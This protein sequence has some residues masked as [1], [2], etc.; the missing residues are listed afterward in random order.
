MSPLPFVDPSQATLFGEG[1]RPRERKPRQRDPLWDAVVYC[2]KIH[3]ASLTASGRG[4]TNRAVKEL[5]DAGATPEQVVARSRVYIEKWRQT[6][7]AAALARQW[8]T[9]TESPLRVRVA[10]LAASESVTAER[11]AELAQRARA[12][13]EG[14]R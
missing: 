5:R 14:R 6:P 4:M 8:A 13:M 9:L 1:S 12:W 3:E 10:P 11:R 2:C 7:T